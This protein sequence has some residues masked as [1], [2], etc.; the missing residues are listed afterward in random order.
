MQTLA[1][2]ADAARHAGWNVERRDRFTLSGMTLLTLDR[3]PTDGALILAWFCQGRFYEASLWYGHDDGIDGT[4]HT[5]Q[6]TTVAG[7]LRVGALEAA[8]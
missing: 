4:A 7:W 5:H 2:L 1:A 6:P 3:G 8:S